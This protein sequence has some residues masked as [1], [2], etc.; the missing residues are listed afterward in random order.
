MGLMP[1][2][3]AEIIYA[4]FFNPPGVT[5]R[6]MYAL[7]TV[8]YVVIVAFTHKGLTTRSPFFRD[9]PV[10]Q[11]LGRHVIFALSVGFFFVTALLVFAT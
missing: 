4:A 10:A 8:A 9:L 6:L 7:G 5:L 1:Y 11:I 3:G 2:A